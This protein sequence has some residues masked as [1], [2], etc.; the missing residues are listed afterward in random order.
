M[1][2]PLINMPCLDMIA[3]RVVKGVNFVNIRDVGDPVECCKVYCTA[4]ADRLAMLDIAATGRK[5]LRARGFVV[6]VN[7]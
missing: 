5:F 1:N 2:Q 6:S 3:G 4:G 7:G